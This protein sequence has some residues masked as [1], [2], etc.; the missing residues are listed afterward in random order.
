MD[1]CSWVQKA[2][3]EEWTAEIFDAEIAVNRRSAVPGMLRLL[4][5]ALH[6]VEKSPEKRPEMAEV[7]RE[8]EEIQFLDQ[9]E[10]ENDQSLDRSY[11]TDDSISSVASGKA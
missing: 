7:A 5:I 2:I 8:V 3:R 1:L 11:T 10:D 6:C 9:S 4:E